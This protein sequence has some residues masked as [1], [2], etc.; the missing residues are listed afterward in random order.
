MSK[1]KQIRREILEKLELIA[2]KTDLPLEDLKHKFVRYVEYY[3]K[4][5]PSIGIQDLE[6]MILNR[7][8]TPAVQKRIS[9]SSS[10]F[11]GVLIFKGES[12]WINKDYIQRVMAQ[13]E[14]GQVP[15][16]RVH[17][18]PLVI[19]VDENGNPIEPY[20]VRYTRDGNPFRVEVDKERVLYGWVFEESKKIWRLVEIRARGKTAEGEHIADL[21][22]D[23]PLFEEV[24]IRG[25][26]GKDLNRVYLSRAPFDNGK[27][28]AKTDF[29]KY[30]MST[31][32]DEILE[33]L[34]ERHVEFESVRDYILQNEPYDLFW[35]RATL[36][37]ISDEPSKFGSY[38]ISLTS[39]SIETLLS[40][41]DDEENYIT[42]WIKPGV[43]GQD[44]G[45][46]SAVIVF[47]TGYVAQDGT[48]KVIVGGIYPEAIFNDDIDVL[49]DDEMIEDDS[50]ADDE[51]VDE[52]MNDLVD[53]DELDVI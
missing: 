38:R 29:S 32:I 15:S 25:S 45:A 8:A 10:V 30:K 42:A 12:R 51:I 43:L 22:E 14:N 24:K 52:I 49:V 11:H 13:Y 47:A 5:Y 18:K 20:V 40:A 50:V 16:D 1:V 9:S 41:I 2:D 35:F 44:C 6:R 34:E 31:S 27:F 46:N 36:T 3:K 37:D 33:E 4:K 39:T 19:D 23:V 48:P 7:L 53:D 28:W 26:S 17:G 21:I